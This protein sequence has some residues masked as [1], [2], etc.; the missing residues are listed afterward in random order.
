MP[1]VCAL[2]NAHECRR[3]LLLHQCWLLAAAAAAAA[4]MQC[5]A[6]DALMCCCCCFGHQQ[7]RLKCERVAVAAAGAVVAAAGAAAACPSWTCF[8]NADGRGVLLTLKRQ[9]SA[10]AAGIT[11]HT[12]ITHHTPP[13]APGATLQASLPPALPSLGLRHRVR[14]RYVRHAFV[15]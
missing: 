11:H 13:S 5:A 14:E 7:Q 4:C 12:S 3:R 15:L 8:R 6:A 9:W 2:C 10:A 1:C